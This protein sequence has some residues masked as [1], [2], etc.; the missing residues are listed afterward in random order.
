MNIGVALPPESRHAGLCVSL[1]WITESWQSKS[2]ANR[3]GEAENRVRASCSGQLPWLQTGQQ[4]PLAFHKNGSVGLNYLLPRSKTIIH[5]LMQKNIPWGLL[6]RKQETEMWITWLS[7]RTAKGLFKL[8]MPKVRG[9]AAAR[10]PVLGKPATTESTH[11]PCRPLSGIYG[12]DQLHLTTPLPTIPHC[13]CTEIMG[14]SP[15][16]QTLQPFPC[17]PMP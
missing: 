13:F 17:D 5:H 14:N 2:W 11:S 7:G 6:D 16:S 9:A 1:C 12:P 8:S 4:T 3:A 15:L 10:M